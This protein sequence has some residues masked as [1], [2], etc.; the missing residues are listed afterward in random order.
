[1]VLLPCRK[2][3]FQPSVI[4]N[5]DVPL[6]CFHHL[7][8]LRLERDADSVA[9]GE[10]GRK[11]ATHLADEFLEVCALRASVARDGNLLSIKALDR[12]AWVRKV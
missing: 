4:H 1:M 2:A 11:C 3:F 12:L 7:V 5:R 10:I 9:G 6:V 8:A